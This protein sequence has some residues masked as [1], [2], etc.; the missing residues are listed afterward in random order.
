MCYFRF[1]CIYATRTA[2]E[3]KCTA[4]MV[5]LRIF[6]W[7]FKSHP[8]WIQYLNADT[9]RTHIHSAASIKVFMTSRDG[10]FKYLRNSDDLNVYVYIYIGYYYDACF[11]LSVTRCRQKSLRDEEPYKKYFFDRILFILCIACR[12]GKIIWIPI[13][14]WNYTV[15]T[16]NK[17]SL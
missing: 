1:D 16:G 13:L 7:N 9:P 6:K 11:P 3:L 15:K 12:V 4:R 17:V 8:C 5:S 14:K 10:K 2:P